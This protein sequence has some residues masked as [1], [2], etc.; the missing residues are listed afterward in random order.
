MTA[1]RLS[2]VT[3]G[4]RGRPVVRDVTVDVPAGSWLAII[5]PNGAG[6]STLLKSV[7]G[8]VS[9]TGD[10]LVGGRSVAALGHRERARLIGYAPQTPSLPE[11]LTVTDYV[12]LGRTPHLGPLGR[13]GH[14]DLEIVSGAL[15]RLDLAGLS[16]RP[17]RTLSGGERQRAVLA[18]V[19][20]QQAGVLLL[21]EPTTGLDIGHAQSLLELVDQLRKADGTT[22]ISTLH[23]LTLAA[24]YPDRVLLLD[25]GEVAAVGTPAEVLTAD[26]LSRHYAA[27]VTVLTAPD[28]SLVVS[29]SRR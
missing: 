18:R 23:D 12:L 21:D 28:G 16:N 20:A 8:L 4:Y 2:A 22:V 14:S 10:V 11:G 19:L 5:G 13:E 1:L 17:L 25:N 26:R 6:K 24:Q 27:S 29:P 9:A 7:A 15:R 3:A